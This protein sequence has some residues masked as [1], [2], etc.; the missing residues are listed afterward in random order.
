MWD[1]EDPINRLNPP[2]CDLIISILKGTVNPSLIE[3]MKIIY[4]SQNYIIL[5]L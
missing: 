1:L 4:T 3:P 5:Q 2:L